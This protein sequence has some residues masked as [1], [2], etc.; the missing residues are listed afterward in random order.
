VESG[1]SQGEVRRALGHIRRELRRCDTVPPA[2]R[3]LVERL[4]PLLRERASHEYFYRTQL[5]RA[6]GQPEVEPFTAT[7]DG[8]A[9]VGRYQR[10][11]T[12]EAWLLPSDVPDLTAWVTAALTEWHRLAPDR[13][14]G[15]P[16]WSRRP[17]WATDSER[18]LLDEVASLR[19]ERLSVTARLDAREQ[20]LEAELERARRAGDVYERALLTA[21]DDE[22]V[23]AVLRALTEL[24]FTVVDADK[25]AEETERLEDLRVSDP[26]EPH[27]LALV[28]VKGYG[29]GAQTSALTQFLRFDRRYQKRTGRAPDAL[30]Y[31]ANQFKDRDPASRQLILQSNEQ[32][33]ATFAEVGGVVIDTVELFR[34][35]DAVRRAALTRADAR[36]ALRR[37]AGRFVSPV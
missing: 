5:S 30:W 35:I 12:A 29:K 25:A 4:E 28:E 1:P 11:K 20:E 17:E 31:V 14:P 32:D 26:A 2:A 16:D 7:A 21:Q 24:G 19:E 10:S 3:P 13:F 22:L 9:L 33:V 36:V 6:A 8:K 27:W 15:S 34:L 37:A 23:Q 18:A